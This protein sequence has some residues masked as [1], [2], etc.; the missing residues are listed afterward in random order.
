[1]HSEEHEP[2]KPTPQTP[3]R[4][5]AAIPQPGPTPWDSGRAGLGVSRGWSCASPSRAASPAPASARCRGSAPPEGGA[6]GPHARL[7]WRLGSAGKGGGAPERTW[8]EPAPRDRSCCSVSFL[9]E[10]QRAS[11]IKGQDLGPRLVLLIVV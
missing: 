11:G 4:A 9:A 3:A 5:R 7:S 10:P 8:G 1:M 2:P 6:A